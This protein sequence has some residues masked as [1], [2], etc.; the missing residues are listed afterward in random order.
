M[1]EGEE[2]KEEEGRRTERRKGLVRVTA[3]ASFSSSS[4]TASAEST[5]TFKSTED[6]FGL[7]AAALADVAYKDDTAMKSLKKSR[8]KIPMQLIEKK[9]LLLYQHRKTNY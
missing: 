3:R 9:K 6:R 4:A 2:G 8:V 7:K 5:H 1:R